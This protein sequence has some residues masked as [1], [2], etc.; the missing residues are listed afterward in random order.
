MSTGDDFYIVITVV[1]KKSSFINWLVFN[2]RRAYRFL[3]FL[4]PPYT[5]RCKTECLVFIVALY[6]SYILTSNKYI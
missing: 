3:H 1:E 5:T 2:S 4:Q 6:V